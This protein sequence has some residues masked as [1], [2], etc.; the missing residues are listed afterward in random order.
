MD[1]Q[2]VSTTCLKEEKER[3]KEE[4]AAKRK[5]NKF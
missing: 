1:L 5:N 2:K 4:K 3:A